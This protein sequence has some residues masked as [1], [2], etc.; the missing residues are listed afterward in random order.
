MNLLLLTHTIAHLKIKQ[1]VYQIVNR[2]CKK[3]FILVSFVKNED[4]CALDRFCLKTPCWT[5]NEFVFLNLSSGFSSWNDVSYG[6]LWAYNLNYMDWLL[7]E[8]MSFEEGAHWI[9]KFINELPMN[10]IGL[11][12]YPIALRGINWIKFMTKYQDELTDDR[13]EI[14]NNYLYSQYVLLTKKLEYHLLGNHL[15]EDAYSLFIASIYFSQREWYKKASALLVRE[16]EEQILNDGCHYEQSPMYHCILLDRLLDCYNFSIHNERF[17]GQGALSRFMQQVAERMLGFLSEICYEDGTFPLFNDSAEKIAPTPHEIFDYAKRL[18]LKSRSCKLSDS[19]YRR[20]K[21]STM[22]VFVDVGNITASYQ[23]GHSHADTFSYDLRIYGIPFIV[24]TGISTYNKTAR[25]L[26]ERTTV[27]HNTVSIGGKN[28]SEVWS[29]FRV[30]KQAKVSVQVDEDKRIFV[31]HNGFG[32]RNRVS[33][34]FEMLQESFAITDRAD[35]RDA[36]S[37]IH[38]APEIDKVTIEKDLIKTCLGSVRVKNYS[39]IVHLKDYASTEYNSLREI[40]VIAIYFSNECSY[41]IVVN[42]KV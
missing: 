20:M 27:A 1:F 29:G 6:L 30:G 5:G 13:R 40:N 14:W 24:D 33:R 37:Y 17:H 8:K 38:F 21:N 10:K 39:K 36:V 32:R 3:K 19:G 12:S 26:Y 4:N 11:D 18:G 31:T 2:F 25:R 35:S 42:S 34:Q 41:E 23:P 9:D 22:E 28:S 16:L 7:Q 15:L